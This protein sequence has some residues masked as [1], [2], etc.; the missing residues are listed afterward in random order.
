MERRIRTFAQRRGADDLPDYL[1]S[2]QRD[3]GRAR[4]VPR[5]RDDQRLPAVAQPG[6]VGRR[7]SAT[8]LPELARGRPR[9]RV[10][11]RLLVRRRGLHAGR[12][13][14]RRVPGA[15]ASDHRHRHRPPHGRPRPRRAASPPRTR[16]PRPRPPLAALVRAAT[17]T[18]GAAGP[19]LRAHRRASRPATC[20][21]C[22]SRARRYDLVLCRNTVIYFTEEV[23]DALHARLVESLRPGGYL[24]D[25]LH[26]ARHRAARARPGAHPP[27]R[28]PQ[29]ADGR[30]PSTS[31]CSSPRPRSTSR[32]STSPSCASRSSP[33]TARRSTRSSASRTP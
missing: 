3:R 26:R 16:A 21:A 27:L 24:V 22:A 5:P 9:P 12:A 6:A 32:R 11:R 4:R 17:A 2:L 8:V 7:C 1:A 20:C 18:A 28:L 33:T 23:R 14:P 13:S 19:E 31:R 29:G 15:R 30:S 25:R 10:E